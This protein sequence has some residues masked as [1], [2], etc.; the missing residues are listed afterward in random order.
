MSKGIW[1][2]V[3]GSLA[4]AQRLDVVANNLANVNTVGF[5]RDAAAFRQ[6]LTDAQSAS[7]R[8]DVPRQPPTDKELH[9]LDGRDSA[10][11]VLD[12]V[13]TDHGQGMIKSTNNP[14]D[15]AIEGKGFFEVL[16][17]EG[18]R[19]T[20]NGSFLIN[21]DGL[22][23]T[24]EGYPVLSRG[25]DAAAPPATQP[26]EPVANASTSSAPG[27]PA[28]QPTRE[29]LLARAISF[30]TTATDAGKITVNGDGAIFRGREPVA[31]LS[32]V[33]FI[34]PKFLAK[35]GNALFRNEEPANLLRDPGGS[36]IRQGMLETANVNPVKELTE[37]LNA[38]RMFE[39]NQKVVK[40][41]GELEARAVN[42]IGKL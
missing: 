1:P 25:G 23:V 7:A 28:P 40:T 27:A 38:T 39:A 5:K 22:L 17:P 20:R 13:F 29:E 3:S 2:A 24:M 4:Q 42:E 14:T 8:E 21:P 16:T 9:R 34:N 19:F 30:D 11:V 10:Y 15:L 37:M 32:V 26:G 35:T 6:V 12:G 33:E 18:V 31:E 36:T 41:Y